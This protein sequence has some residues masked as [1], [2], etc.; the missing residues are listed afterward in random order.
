MQDSTMAL[1]I[2]K[3]SMFARYHDESRWRSYVPD[4]GSN[5]T[6]CNTGR[7]SRALQSIVGK[8]RVGVLTSQ[9]HILTAFHTELLEGCTQG[10][11]ETGLSSSRTS[12]SDARDLVNRELI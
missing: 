4:N 1:L 10:R 3:L 6:R 2:L 5:C 8:A 11:G 9:P 7:Q 12:K